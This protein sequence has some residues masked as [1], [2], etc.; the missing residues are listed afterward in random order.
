MFCQSS[1]IES[2]RCHSSTWSDSRVVVLL[3]KYLTSADPSCWPLN[4]KRD[5]SWS[6]PVL[7][8]GTVKSRSEFFVDLPAIL[9][10]EELKL[11]FFDLR[12]TEQNDLARRRRESRA[13]PA[14]LHLLLLTLSKNLSEINQRRNVA[15]AKNR[16]C[17]Q[18]AVLTYVVYKSTFYMQSAIK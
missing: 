12:N 14:G 3:D 16:P 6:S 7:F 18:F 2:K 8:A 17:F 15:T 4:R 9:C 5:L 13:A 1:V 11:S 10:E